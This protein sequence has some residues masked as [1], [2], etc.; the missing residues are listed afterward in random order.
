M[1]FPDLE[2]GF[3]DAGYG[4]AGA[5]SDDGRKGEGIDPAEAPV[6]GDA[7]DTESHKSFEAG[8]SD[9]GASSGSI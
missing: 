9:S 2:D 8:K 6:K 5:E 4:L 3:H 1:T 7:S